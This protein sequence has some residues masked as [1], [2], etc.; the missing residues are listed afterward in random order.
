M[1]IAKRPDNSSGDDGYWYVM[2]PNPWAGAVAKL[3]TY[4]AVCEKKVQVDS[5]LTCPI[6]GRGVPIGDTNFGELFKRMENISNE[7]RAASH[8]RSKDFRVD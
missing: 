4:C 6:C 7:R 2:S 3:E 1:S 5:D 8:K